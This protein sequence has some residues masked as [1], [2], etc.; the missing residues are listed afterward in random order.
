[1]NSRSQEEQR[2]SSS[3]LISEPEPGELLGDCFKVLGWFFDG[4]FH[5]PLSVA[6]SFSNKLELSRTTEPSSNF[7]LTEVKIS[8]ELPWLAIKS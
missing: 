6:T 2:N 7:T 5:E 4:S 3:P 8:D 1:M